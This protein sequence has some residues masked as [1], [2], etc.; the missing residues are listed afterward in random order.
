MRA[1]VEAEP[2]VRKDGPLMPRQKPHELIHQLEGRS[3][4]NSTR[5][6][7]YLTGLTRKPVP[8]KEERRLGRAPSLAGRPRL[9]GLNSNSRGAEVKMFCGDVKGL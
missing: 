3:A 4:E 9:I 6:Q 8:R 2:P 5:G 7:N 1:Q